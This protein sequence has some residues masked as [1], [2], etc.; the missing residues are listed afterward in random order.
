MKDSNI[1][2]AIVYKVS[3]FLRNTVKIKREDA[4]KALAACFEELGLEGYLQL[5][6][7]NYLY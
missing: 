2:S 6:V 1:D 3:K 5:V 4:S 7:K